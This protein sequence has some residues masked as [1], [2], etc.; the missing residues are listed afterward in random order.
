VGVPVSVLVRMPVNA[1]G[2]EIVEATLEVVAENV[3]VNVPV[4]A[5]GLR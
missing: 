1:F 2:G 5:L 4:G 3:L